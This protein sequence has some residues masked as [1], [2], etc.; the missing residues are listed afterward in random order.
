MA[1]ILP[2]PTEN[3]PVVSTVEEEAQKPKRHNG[4]LP[5][6]RRPIWALVT[7]V[8]LAIIFLAVGYIYDVVTNNNQDNTR[9]QD[10]AYISKAL[11]EY[12]SLYHYYPTLDQ[13]NS[14]TSAFRVFN[15]ELNSKKFED[16]NSTSNKLVSKPASNSYAYELRPANC[17]NTTLD[18]TSYE[19]IATLSDGK[20]Y[21]ITS[22]ANSTESTSLGR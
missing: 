21:I 3:S 4:H 9:R 5:S 7:L 11:N 17:N 22:P 12:Y 8:V 14:N 2:E 19:L 20:Q 16:P 1:D 10:L 18:C 13:I 6:N 15:P